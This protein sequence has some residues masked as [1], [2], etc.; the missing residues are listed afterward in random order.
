MPLALERPR[1]DTEGWC[2][3]HLVAAHTIKGGLGFGVKGEIRVERLG[4]KIEAS[5]LKDFISHNAFVSYF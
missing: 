4:F 3:A 5:G 1:H 2:A